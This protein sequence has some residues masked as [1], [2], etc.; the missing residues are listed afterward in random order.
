MQ[1]LFR[2]YMNSVHNKCP[3]MALGRRHWTIFHKDKNHE[4]PPNHFILVKQ[5]LSCWESKQ[6]SNA[7]TKIAN[8]SCP[9]HFVTVSSCTDVDEMLQCL[10]HHTSSRRQD[11][12]SLRK[13]NFQF[14]LSQVTDLQIMPQPPKM[15]VARKSTGEA[16]GTMQSY[17]MVCKVF[18]FC[19]LE[20]CQLP[21][22]NTCQRH[23]VHDLVNI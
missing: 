18:R 17:K 3:K 1:W 10:E 22:L 13:C 20:T 11:K 7:W 9:C 21:I 4:V 19:N 16:T 14:D 12:C 2:R 23:H 8:H 6:A 5:N 15:C